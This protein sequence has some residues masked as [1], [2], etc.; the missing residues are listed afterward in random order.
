MVVSEER[1]PRATSERRPVQELESLLPRGKLA[2]HNRQATIAMRFLLYSVK[3]HAK[4]F[5]P[6]L[7][8]VSL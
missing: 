7:G 2:I 5:C 8:R 6:V 4:V 1:N 3:A